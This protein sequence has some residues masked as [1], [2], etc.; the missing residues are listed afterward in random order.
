MLRKRERERERKK[1]NTNELYVLEHL[2]VRNLRNLNMEKI[3]APDIGQPL[4]M[5]GREIV[6]KMKAGVPRFH[7][8]FPWRVYKI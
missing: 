3:S 4:T 2:P 1:K 6:N 7:A 8:L 5:K